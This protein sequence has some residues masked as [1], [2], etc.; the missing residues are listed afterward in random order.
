MNTVS[1]HTVQ[2]TIRPNDYRRRECIYKAHKSTEM[3]CRRK[4]KNI[5]ESKNIKSDT[6]KRRFNTNHGENSIA[7][8]KCKTFSLFLFMLTK[9]KRKLPIAIEMI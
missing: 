7:R 3:L 6:M 2:H 5:N 1:G 4:T 8:G 9:K